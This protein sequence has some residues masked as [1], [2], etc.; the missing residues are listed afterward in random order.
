VLT[1]VQR[2]GATREK[3]PE[4]VRGQ[5]SRLP[6]VWDGLC[7]AVPFNDPTRDSARDLVYNVA[8]ESVF[9]TLDWQRDNRGNPALHLDP[10]SFIDYPNTPAHNKPSTQLTAYVRFRRAGAGDVAGGIFYKIYDFFAPGSSTGVSWGIQHDDAGDNTLGA[11]VGV[12]ATINYWKDPAYV[13]NTTDWISVALRWRSGAAPTMD[14]LGER[15]NVISTSS[16]GSTLT[17]TIPYAS[18]DFPIR[19]N[20]QDNDG[21]SYNVAYSQALVWSRRLTDT[22]LQALVADPYGWYSPRR[23]TIGLS[24]PYPLVGGQSFVRQVSTG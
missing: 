15:G 3:P 21:V 6:W 1:V 19:L 13:T 20:S 18:G 9:G 22:E 14:I 8:P 24:S 23:E 16:F 11:N 2:G 4:V 12:G 17:G 10:S 7:F 5:A